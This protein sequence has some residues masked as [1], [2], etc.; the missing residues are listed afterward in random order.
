MTRVLETRRAVVL[1][2]GSAA[3]WAASVLAELLISPHADDTTPTERAFAA[4][5]KRSLDPT[6]QLHVLGRTYLSS[7]PQRPT[8]G[9]LVRELVSSDGAA[10]LLSERE[11]VDFLSRCVEDDFAAGRIIIV[12]GWLLSRTEAALCSLMLL[13]DAPGAG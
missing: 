5:L 13:L 10:T 11:I 1:V 2:L 6:G 9:I 4:H 8:V 12:S 7:L 3:A